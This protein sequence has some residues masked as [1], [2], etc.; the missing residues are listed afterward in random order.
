MGWPNE[1]HYHDD[2]SRELRDCRSIAKPWNGAART[3]LRL[4]D[5]LGSPA[6]GKGG[7]PSLV[8][9]VLFLGSGEVSIQRGHHHHPS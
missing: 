2:G 6:A 7:Q 4:E 5:S 1:S 8:A 3:T 9:L